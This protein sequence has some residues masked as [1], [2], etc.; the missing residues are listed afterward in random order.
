[1]G[2][3]GLQAVAPVAA[4]VPSARPGFWTGLAAVPRGFGFLLQTPRAWPFAWVPALVLSA[5][6][7]LLVEACLHWVRPAVLG[8]MPSPSSAVLRY[9]TEALGWLATLAVALFGF[10]VAL[11]LT[12]PL[13]A[14]ALERIVGL[15]EERVGAPA[16]RPLGFFSEMA[17]GARA[18]LTAALFTGPLVV[19]AWIVEL[20][21]PPAAFVTV[22]LKLL[23]VALGLAW[24][25]LDYPLTLRGIGMRER[26]R[27]VRHEWRATLGFG[28]GFA[29][30]FWLPCLNVALLPVGVAAATDLLWRIVRSG[31]ST[32]PERPPQ[33]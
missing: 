3:G 27:F 19:L 8:L 28:L 21:L 16:R 6:T 12:P 24:N 9:G 29:L 7:W 22:P 17:C 26:L 33:S 5:L 14:P 20:L 30:L 25:L 10:I 13:C 11:N 32:L 15:C 4:G 23:L 2:G 31:A 1:M 18:T